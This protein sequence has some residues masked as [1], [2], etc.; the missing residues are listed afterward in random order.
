MINI[1]TAVQSIANY[2]NHTTGRE[3]IAKKNCENSQAPR[4]A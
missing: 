3:I 4:K 2:T 1:S